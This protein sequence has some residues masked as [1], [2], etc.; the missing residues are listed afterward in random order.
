MKKVFFTS[1]SVIFTLIISAQG[2]FYSCSYYGEKARL[3]RFEVCLMNNSFV[4]GEVQDSRA[5][6]IVDKIVAEVG[7]PRNFLLVECPEIS[8][9]KAVNYL[10]E[11]GSLRYIV[12]DD[13][14]LRNLDSLSASKEQYWA[15]ISIMAHEIG[16]HLCGHTLDSLGSRPDKELEADAFSGFIMYKLGASLQQAQAALV[17]MTKEYGDVE[18]VSTH[19]P[20][21]NRLA[22]I[23]NGWNKGWSSNYRQQQ[24]K[25]ERPSL[26]AWEDIALEVYNDAYLLNKTGKYN[27]AIKK[28]NVAIN[29]KKNFAD[30]Y[31]QRGLAEANLLKS[32]AAITTLDSALAIDPDLNLARI[33]KG[34]ALVN[35]KSYLLAEGY[36]TAA[37]KRD[38]TDPAL[39]AERALLW[40]A[41]G[42]YDK[43]IGDASLAVALGYQDVHIPLGVLGYGYMKKKKYTSSI[44]FFSE[45]L[46]YNPL[47]EFSR[48]WGLETVKLM[49]AEK[50]KVMAP[51]KKLPV[52]TSTNK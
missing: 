13:A 24:N 34:K 17:T 3:T 9:C 38:S 47:D 35:T 27:E 8:N 1:I 21:T 26:I 11:T 22:A 30:A 15:S 46:K 40:Q 33:Y 44:H 37:I 43:A 39:Y 25:N 19:P 52:K 48:K 50:K 23:R 7:L 5:S 31:V 2:K 28:L 49:E 45:A 16:H 36:F 20:L 12:Y 29:L 51:V 32:S 18:I 41:K 42:Q 14:F 10:A 6:E 4:F